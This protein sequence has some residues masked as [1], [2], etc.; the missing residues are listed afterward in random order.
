[1]NLSVRIYGDSISMP[2]CIDGIMPW[3]S[4]PAKLQGKLGFNYC[5]LNRSIGYGDVKKISRLFKS[6]K[7]YFR[8]NVG[9]VVFRFGIVDCAPRPIPLW[10]RN[11]IG[12]LPKIVRNKIVNFIHNHRT[13]M[14]RH[15]SFV[16]TSASRFRRK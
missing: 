10:L 2:R 1:M 5:V 16:I 9:L 7:F 4:W 6:D 11:L 13:S 3:E 14:L 15:M 12:F 8:G